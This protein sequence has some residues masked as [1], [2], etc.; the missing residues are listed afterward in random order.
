VFAQEWRNTYKQ[1]CKS[2]A[3]DPT[4]PWKSVD[5]HHY[6]ALIELLRAW[7]L[8]G[9]W[10]EDEVRQL[11]LVWH[12]LDPW[13]DA[14][15]GIRTLNQQFSTCTLSNGNLALLEDLTA[16][17]QLQFSRLFSAETFNSYKPSPSV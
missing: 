2:I 14:A 6:D 1:F 7:S 3:A 16:R 17:C 5:D 12:R 9:L 4:L 11:S 8:E 13:P 10:E 15:D